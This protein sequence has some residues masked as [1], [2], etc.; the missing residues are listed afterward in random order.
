MM[1]DLKMVYLNGKVGLITW[2]DPEVGEDPRIQRFKKD[3]V[4]SVNANGMI[5]LLVKLY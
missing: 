1:T 3:G 5:V 4:R 2:Y